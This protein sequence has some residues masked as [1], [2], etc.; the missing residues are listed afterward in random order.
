MYSCKSLGLKITK[1]K[2]LGNIIER[3]WHINNVTSYEDFQFKM[4]RS[5]IIWLCVGFNL[6]RISLKYVFKVG[7]LIIF[8]Y[9]C[10]YDM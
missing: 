9:C 2:I 4:L 8:V 5:D 1:I 6:D 3:L 7:I 10:T